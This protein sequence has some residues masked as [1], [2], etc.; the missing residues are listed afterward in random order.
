MCEYAAVVVVVEIVNIIGIVFICT[1]DIEIV[2]EE[3]VMWKVGVI[4]KKTRKF[5]MFFFLVSTVILDQFL[6]YFFFGNQITYKNGHE[7]LNTYLITSHF[8]LKYKVF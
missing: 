2:Q 8:L 1:R 6:E 5:Q 4:R 7:D 3:W